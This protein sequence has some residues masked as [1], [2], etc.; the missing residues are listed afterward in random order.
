[1]NTDRLEVYREDDN[2]ITQRAMLSFVPSVF[3]T[4]GLFASFR[5]RM[6]LLLKT[7]WVKSRLQWTE[8]F[9]VKENE[10]Y[11]DWVGELVEF[12]NIPLERQFFDKNFHIFTDTPLEALYTTDKLRNDDGDGIEVS[13]V[14]EKCRIDPLEH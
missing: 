5:M 2:K 1:M 3:D 12:K 9:D 14:I 6:H 13:L 8:R 11:L 7:I 10:Q 4:L